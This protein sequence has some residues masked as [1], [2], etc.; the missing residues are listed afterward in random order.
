M[1]GLIRCRF[2][3]LKKTKGLPAVES[4]EYIYELQLFSPKSESHSDERKEIVIYIGVIINSFGLDGVTRPFTCPMVY[5]FSFS[6]QECILV[7]VFSRW[8]RM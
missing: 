4:L 5:Y 3:Q 7:F 1:Q 2:A 8:L 6:F